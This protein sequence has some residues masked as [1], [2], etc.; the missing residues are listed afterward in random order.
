VLDEDTG[1]DTSPAADVNLPS[2]HIRY[3]QSPDEIGINGVT[4][5]SEASWNDD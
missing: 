3:Q 2:R 1:V 4:S 5:T